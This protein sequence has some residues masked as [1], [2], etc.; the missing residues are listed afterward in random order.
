MVYASA[1]GGAAVTAQI[2]P[3]VEPRADLWPRPTAS[4]PPV[5]LEAVAALTRLPW[6]LEEVR[7]L[8][9][10]LQQMAEEPVLE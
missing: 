4:A 9:I 6:A 5:R 10:L 7:E 1:F 2:L 3:A 8:S